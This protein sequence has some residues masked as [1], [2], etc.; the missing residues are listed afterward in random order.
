MIKMWVQKC[1]QEKVSLALCFNFGERVLSVAELF[2]RRFSK[3]A[4][5]KVLGPKIMK[6]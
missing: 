2:L 6:V 1:L 4:S 3:N 5:I